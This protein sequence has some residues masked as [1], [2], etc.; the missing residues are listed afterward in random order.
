MYIQYTYC[1]FLFRL[2]TTYLTVTSLYRD[3]WRKPSQYV[4]AQPFF[5]EDYP[6]YDMDEE[7]EK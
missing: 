2:V 5:H 6:A 1:F 7:D 3:D 4:H